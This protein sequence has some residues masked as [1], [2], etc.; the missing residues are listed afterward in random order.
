MKSRFSASV[1]KNVQLDT[2]F[3]KRTTT[4]AL[5]AREVKQVNTNLSARCCL[6][7]HASCY[8]PISALLSY[9]S[10]GIKSLAQRTA[11]SIYP[12]PA[13]VVAISRQSLQRS[14]EHVHTM[15]EKLQTMSSKSK[16]EFI[17]T[18]DRAITAAVPLMEYGDINFDE[19]LR[20]RIG[21]MQLEQKQTS[22][23]I[24]NTQSMLSENNLS[25]ELRFHLRIINEF[26]DISSHFRRP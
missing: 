3:E 5:N 17:E 22:N 21:S 12:T 10:N 25:D 8:D 6:N 26:L 11:L 20:A 15:I 23:A 19:I 18:L 13:R 2:V 14:S 1:N 4:G 7:I 24:S 9:A 16:D